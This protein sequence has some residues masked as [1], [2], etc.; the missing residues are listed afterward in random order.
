MAERDI[1]PQ[2][3]FEIES[4]EAEDDARQAIERLREVI[5]YHDHCYYVL[6]D[7][8]ISDAEYDALMQDLRRLEEKF[9]GL[10]APDSPTQQLN[11]EIR[12]ELG[13]AAHPS[14]MLSLKAVYKAQEVLEFDRRCRKRLDTDQVPYVAE[15]KY[16]GLAV[17]L[18][19]E[20]GALETASTRGDGETG[21][22]ITPNVKTIREI[23][24]R[25]RG[26]QG[27]EIPQRLV[28]RGEIYMRVDEFKAL[29][30]R[31]I[32]SGEDPFANPRNA[33]AGSVRQL[34]ANV[35][36]E[37]PLHI[38]FYE[39]ADIDGPEPETQWDALHV[40][41]TWGLRANLERAERCDGPDDMIRYHESLAE[42]R[43]DLAYEIDGV[44]YKVDDLEKQAVLGARARDPRWALA[45]KFK[46]RR[47]ESTVEDIIVQVGRTGK[48]TPIALL[49]T[50]EIGGVEVSRASLHNQSE[51]ERKD[52]RV[53]DRVLVE[54][55][56]DVIPQIVK[57]FPESRDGAEQVFEMPEECPICG[58]KV[59][60]SDD[61]KLTRCTN[62]SCPAQLRGRLTHYASRGGLDIE[63]LGEKT[64]EKLIK[65]DLVEGIADLYALRKDDLLSL[66]GF[67][68]KSAENL[69]AEI[70]ASA[71]S[72]LPRFLYA[73]GIPLVGE[74]VARVLAREF[75][76]LDEIRD[77]SQDE[78]E[79]IDQIGPAV[80]KNLRA[81]FDQPDNREALAAIQSAG[82][83]LRNPLAPE[84]DHPLDGLTFVFT[85]SL[86]RW[87]RDEVERKVEEMGGRATS[88]V[89][90]ET[91]YVVAGPGA[92]GKL[93]QAREEDVP[94]MDEEDFLRLLDELR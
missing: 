81:F 44:V 74:H 66:E 70:Q 53:G 75:D 46:P 2:P 63:G 40:L 52:I 19:Y 23:P 59:V 92:G 37:R 43:E 61:K 50:V 1:E 42:E 62:I 41:P 65:K 36:A 54:R 82:M 6:D 34:D 27:A 9:P 48:L 21:E 85:G 89:S 22:D 24:M 58:S 5:R 11:G 93:D 45:Y 7:P 13:T 4:I 16:D 55:A 72:T 94:V 69:L 14:P 26:W 79:T 77:A 91:D 78:L 60:T 83:S 31:R 25:L 39:I 68:D 15:P 49:E 35:T 76:T 47:K 51:V 80:A 88:S 30:Q 29:N 56:G 17:E 33:A 32:N 3:E 64:A 87:T 10:V 84:A 86:E 67:G 28:A 20:N 71:E 73:L 8:E 57:S 90:G 18:I 38:F 12:Q